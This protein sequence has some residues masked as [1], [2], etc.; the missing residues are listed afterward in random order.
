MVKGLLHTKSQVSRYLGWSYTHGKR[1][2]TYENSVSL[3]V[4]F[5]VVGVRDRKSEKKI[6][7]GGQKN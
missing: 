3:N 6:E 1:I 5:L 7:I 4:R 2:L